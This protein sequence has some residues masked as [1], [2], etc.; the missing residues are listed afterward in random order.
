M[1]CTMEYPKFIVSNQK[2]THISIQMVRK[3]Q[4]EIRGVTELNTSSK[5]FAKFNGKQIN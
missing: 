3:F 4:T 1:I 2:E 5:L